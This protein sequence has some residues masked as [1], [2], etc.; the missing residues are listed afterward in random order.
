VPLGS[1]LPF[2]RVCS[3]DVWCFCSTIARALVLLIRCC[4]TLSDTFNAAVWFVLRCL[5][6]C[7]AD[8]HKH[9]CWR[10]ATLRRGTLRLGA[11]V[12]VVSVAGSA[13]SR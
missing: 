7:R 6:P 3:V 8:A 4:G 13:D 11:V 1:A 12:I 9:H 10:V 2:Q 5:L